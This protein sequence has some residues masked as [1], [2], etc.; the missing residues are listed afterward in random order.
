MARCRR[1]P[2]VEH[3]GGL[4]RI[5]TFAREIIMGASVNAYW[6]GMTEAQLESQ[7]GFRNDDKQWG[8]WMAER[9][10]DPA[11]P[12]AIRSLNAQ[13]I[14]T[15]KTDGWDDEDVTWVS[16]QE[17]RDAALELRDAVQAKAPEAAVI[18]DSYERGAN[19]GS[20]VEAMFAD[21]LTDVIELANWAEAQGTTRMT[22]EVNW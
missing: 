3:A 12:D 10:D 5:D 7:P 14:L 17:L 13:A 8:N 6:P 11:V 21:D 16:P 22:L 2:R 1:A 9:E 18:L 19:A 4:R 15:C 20:K